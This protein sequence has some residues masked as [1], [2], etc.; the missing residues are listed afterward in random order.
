MKTEQLIRR[1]SS[2]KQE[3]RLQRTLEA[4]L[5]D[6]DY[7]RVSS[8]ASSAVKEVQKTLKT[9]QTQ[10]ARLNAKLEGIDRRW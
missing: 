10:V 9:L 6:K 7:K 2:K 4:A 3:E 5:G 1:R 8:Y